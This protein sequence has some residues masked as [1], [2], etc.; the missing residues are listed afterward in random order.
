MQK[1]INYMHKLKFTDTERTINKWDLLKWKSF[2]K[3]K[4]M[5][6]KTK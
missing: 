1:L 6:N 3:A 2:D 5:A 4:G